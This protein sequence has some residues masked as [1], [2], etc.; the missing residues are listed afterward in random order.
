MMSGLELYGA[1]SAQWSKLLVKKYLYIP[2]QRYLKEMA[3]TYNAAKG[4]SFIVLAAFVGQG[5]RSELFIIERDLESLKWGGVR[6]PPTPILVY[7][8]K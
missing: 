8:T 6:T 1:A 4:V 5:K 2:Q 7:W 3:E